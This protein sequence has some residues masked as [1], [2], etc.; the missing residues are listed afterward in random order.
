LHSKTPVTSGG[1]ILP[2]TH[3]SRLGH[4]KWWHTTPLTTATVFIGPGLTQRRLPTLSTARRHW[5]KDV[6]AAVCPYNIAPGS[7]LNYTS[8]PS[9][10]PK[11]VNMLSFICLPLVACLLAATTSAYSSSSAT[12][13][14]VSGVVCSKSP[15]PVLRRHLKATVPHQLEI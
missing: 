5:S 7:H 9:D 4:S 3:P 1:S 13:Y 6:A 10:Q 15:S 8:T 11:P 2:A 14:T 12:A